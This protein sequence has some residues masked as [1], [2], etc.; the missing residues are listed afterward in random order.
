LADAEATEN[1]T[2]C[3]AGTELGAYLKEGFRFCSSIAPSSSWDRNNCPPTYE[4]SLSYVE[5]VHAEEACVLDKMH[6]L[7]AKKN[8]NKELIREDV[9]ST[10]LPK[11]VAEFD[12]DIYKFCLTYETSELEFNSCARNFAGE[13]LA[14]LSKAITRVARYHCVVHRLLVSCSN[15]DNFL[16]A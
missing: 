3:M 4:Q 12:D 11:N 8:M 2:K 9:A 15:A 5:T 16:G 1:L 10:S 6:W 7:D 13:E 14:T